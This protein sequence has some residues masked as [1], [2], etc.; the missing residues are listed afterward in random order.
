MR[1]CYCTF[2]VFAIFTAA[3]IA[4]FGQTD[5]PTKVSV[6]AFTS[7]QNQ[8]ERYRIGFQDTLAIQIFRHPELTQKVNVNSNGTIN[9][10]RIDTPIIAVCK[11]ERELADA[12]TEAYKKDYLKN[13]EVQVTAIEQKSQSFG[14]LGA[15]EKP[16]YYFISRKVRLLELLSYAGG[17]NKE[18]GS[19]IIVARAGSS[20]NCKEPN[21]ADSP[22]SD[23]IVTMNYRL[24]D[25][26]QAKT[27]L[28]MQ[29]GDI[30]YIGDVDVLYVYGN[31]NKQGPVKI[32]EPITLTQAIASAE[33]LKPATKKDK[34][35]VFRLKEGS[36]QRD[37]FVYNLKEID[38]RKVDDPFLQPNDIVAVSE[39]TTKSIIN[40][41]KNGLTQGVPSLFYRIP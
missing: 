3:S 24:K 41:L 5:A 8:D 7:P 28:V 19:S 26:L 2:F 36:M 33:G 23:D 11:T 37:E 27:S 12:I 35:R 21:E 17:P 16:G 39:D 25:I 18:A 40:A 6:P 22:V 29:P 15:V 31:V 9:L 4:V 13:P 30:V 34:V 20:S 1:A 14:V 32:K 10:F 38:A